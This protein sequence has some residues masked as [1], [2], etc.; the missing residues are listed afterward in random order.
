[1]CIGDRVG[2]GTQICWPPGKIPPQPRTCTRS[3]AARPGAEALAARPATEALA[4][5][6]SSTMV[7][8]SGPRTQDAV[9]AKEPLGP[10]TASATRA[11]GHE[12]LG[13]LNWANRA[14]LAGPW[15]CLRPRCRWLVACLRAELS[16][17]LCAFCSCALSLSRPKAT[18][19]TDPKAIASKCS[20]NPNT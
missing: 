5:A 19:S 13:G 18:G 9:K 14:R 10:R 11:F 4:A 1:M 8:W 12:T 6:A 20:T 2:Q 3:M 7:G 17:K 15:L 16:C